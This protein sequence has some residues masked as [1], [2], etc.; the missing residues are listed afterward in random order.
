MCMFL[1]IWIFLRS[2]FYEM[3]KMLPGIFQH[4]NFQICNFGKIDILR[5][6]WICWQ[7]LPFPS[8]VVS[9]RGIQNQGF[10]LFE[11]E[12]TWCSP[13]LWTVIRCSLVLWTAI[14]RCD[15]VSD[16]SWNHH[17]KHVSCVVVTES[18]KS[19]A[20]LLVQFA[21]PNGPNHATTGSMPARYFLRCVIAVLWANPT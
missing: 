10:D 15:I 9:L 1:K 20:A 16:S 3:W 8:G 19:D 21:F 17:G 6:C 2:G 4:F 13:A 12:N 11:V 14:R 7:Y 5:T 18:V